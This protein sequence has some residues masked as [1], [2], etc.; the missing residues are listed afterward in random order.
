MPGA[1]LGACPTQCT[2]GRTDEHTRRLGYL[3]TYLT[4]GNAREKAAEMDQMELIPADAVRAFM[5]ERLLTCQHCGQTYAKT[6]GG[7]IK[8]CADCI[9]NGVYHR[10]E[11]RGPVQYRRLAVKDCAR[12][13]I[14]YKHPHDQR[15]CLCHQCKRHPVY[16]AMRARFGMHHVP[17]ATVLATME[18]P[19]CANELCGDWLL[20]QITVKHANGDVSK[21][22]NYAI[23]HDHGHCPGSTSCGACIRGVLCQSCNMAIPHTL[24]SVSALGIVDYLKRHANL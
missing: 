12:C 6:V 17:I 14:A 22:L 23:D 2:Y 20:R 5:G 3:Y 18:W 4:L 9:A 24:D 13:G 1:L 10:H 16:D 7:G 19:Y 11:R 15:Y 8:F 21:R